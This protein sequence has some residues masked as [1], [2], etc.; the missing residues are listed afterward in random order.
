MTIG[1]RFGW[2]ALAVATAFVAWRLFGLQFWSLGDHRYVARRVFGRVT[3][4][5]VFDRHGTEVSRIFGTWAE[6]LEGDPATECGAILP[7]QW[8]DDD[9]DGRWD[10][11]ARRVQSGE[12]C[13][14]EYRVDTDHNGAADWEFVESWQ[15]YEETAAAIKA[16]RGY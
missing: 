5:H 3:R 13:F 7:A 2:T 11:W 14:V 6:P 12:R 9:G 1:R 4:V 10:R 15:D 8:Q 16:R